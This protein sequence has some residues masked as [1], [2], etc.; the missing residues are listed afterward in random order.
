MLQGSVLEDQEKHWQQAADLWCVNEA[1]VRHMAEKAVCLLLLD[2]FCC[3]S[4]FILSLTI[5][6]NREILEYPLN[7][8]LTCKSL[9]TYQEGTASGSC[10]YAEEYLHD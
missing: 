5:K 3:Y 10:L 6:K 4:L 2:W 7:F 8:F 9:P 1:N